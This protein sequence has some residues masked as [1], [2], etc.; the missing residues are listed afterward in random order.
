MS[1]TPAKPR[2]TVQVRLENLVNQ[3]AKDITRMTESMADL[4]LAIEDRGWTRGGNQYSATGLDLPA[5]R[6]ISDDLR[7]WIVAGGMMKRI[8]ELRGNSIYGDGVGFKNFAKAVKP[9]TSPNN[10]VK[11]FSTAAMQEINRGH[12]TDGSI[13]FLVNKKTKEISRYGIEETGLPFVDSNDRETTWFVRRTF[14]RITMDSAV[15]TLVDEYYPTDLC[16]ADKVNGSLIAQYDGNVVPINTDFTAVIWDV[17]KQVGWP[18]GIPDLLPSLQWAEKYTDYLKDQS[19]FAKALAQ[20]AWQYRAQNTDQAKKIAAAISPDGIADSAIQTPGMDMKALPGN[21]GVTF[22]NGAALAAQAAAAGEVSKEDLLAEGQYSPGSRLDPNVRKMIGAR[23]QAASEIFK[24]IGKLL[25]APNLEVIW[26]NIDDEDPF[27]DSQMIVAAW[28]TGIY[29]AAEIRGPLAQRTGIEL[30]E[31]SSAV[32]G[33]IIPNN[34]KAI[35]DATAAA[36]AAAKKVSD[37]AKVAA[38]QKAAGVG[39]AVPGTSAGTANKQGKNALGV[40]KLSN[41]DNTARDNGETP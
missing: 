38:D 12:G 8:I 22:D 29:S 32:K 39:T 37:D 41:K 3:Q 19:K 5:L 25:G 16:P 30:A 40:G 21:S 18:L 14:T 27:R 26:P 31:G 33:V 1:T 9:F 24:R 2:N 15:G 34:Q 6:I 20:I 7:S 4:Q 23:R 10:V 28:G 36:V 13:V 35:D 17:N 11:L